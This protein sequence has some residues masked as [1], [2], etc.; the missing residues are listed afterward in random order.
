MKPKTIIEKEIVDLS[1]T[2][3]PIKTQVYT[4]AEK[5]IFLK[6][7]VLSR[8]KFNCLECTHSWKP[9]SQS[10]SCDKYIKCTVCEGRLKMKQYNQV[11]FKEI[12]Y[13]AV[14]DVCGGF[15]VVRIICSHKHMKKNTSPTYFHK[16]VMQH[17]INFKGE[18]RT[19][20]LTTNVF[21]NVY[22]AWQYYS[23]L[24][25][26]P[27]DFQDSP[28]FRINP[29]KIYPNIKVLP[30][31]KRNGFKSGF[32]NIAPQILFTSLL[33][34]TI[35]ETLLKSSQTSL[36]SYYLN[37]HYQNIKQNWQAVKTCL[38][39]KYQIEDF[40]IW[41]D[42]I[43][44]LN[45]FKKDLSSP[46]YVCPIDLHD[47]HDRLVV[48]KR[49]LQRKKY[50]LKMR[51]EIE[52]AQVKYMKEKK[53][54]FGLIFKDENLT[55]RVLENVQDFLDEGDILHHCIFTNEYFKKKD[56][57]ILSARIDNKP[58]ETLEVSLS[59]MEITQ[60]HGNKNSYSQHH[61]VI[62]ELMCKNLYQIRSRMKK[63]KVENC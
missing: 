29:Y 48:K 55:I 33:K 16:E 47:A 13:S 26:R 35:T 46:A 37:V 57:L 8:G 21:S 58:I 44:L 25:I 61:K 40:K 14:L 15:Q 60:C 42:Y 20:S 45:W 32:Y 53:Q 6:W 31:L 54:F 43:A 51:S 12:E 59:K 49:E 52:Q 63:K 22:D 18:V 3:K 36:L 62:M 39:S 10:K 30:V 23:P 34:D 7:G 27:R 56:S 5:N 38:K 28:K 17:W 1:A 24:E 9:Q 2:L 11:H 19:M 4:W 41:E 50:L